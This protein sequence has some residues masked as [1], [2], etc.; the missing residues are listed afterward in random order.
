[1]CPLTLSVTVQR[2]YVAFRH[3]LRDLNRISGPL[4]TFE[5]SVPKNAATFLTLNNGLDKHRWLK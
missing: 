1:M 5:A 3:F 4:D 2:L